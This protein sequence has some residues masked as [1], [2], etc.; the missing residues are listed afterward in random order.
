VLQGVSGNH[1]RNPNAVIQ[2]QC[3]GVPLYILLALWPWSSFLYLN[4]VFVRSY[5]LLHILH[6]NLGYCSSSRRGSPLPYFGCHDQNSSRTSVWNN[7]Y[8]KQ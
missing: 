7:N 4:L 8:G 6:L 5:R 1:P 2:G 3:L